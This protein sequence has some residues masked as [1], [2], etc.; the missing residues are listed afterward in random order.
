MGFRGLLR[1]P[2]TF[3]EIDEETDT[4]FLQNDRLAQGHSS[5]ECQLQYLQNEERRKQ[6][7][8]WAE[9]KNK[10]KRENSD[11]KSPIPPADLIREFYA[12]SSEKQNQRGTTL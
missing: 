6:R 5:S 8:D 4:F 11:P 1:F 9:K 12:F 10:E 2:A 7:K 3:A